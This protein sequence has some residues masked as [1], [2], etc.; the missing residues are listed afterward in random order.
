MFCPKCGN[1]V[2]DNSSFCTGCGFKLDSN[3]NPQP[4]PQPKPQPTH[5]SEPTPVR[6][7]ASEPI[8]PQNNSYDYY[9]KPPKKSGGIGV[10][11][12]I[13]LIVA[14]LVFSVLSYLLL[15]GINGKW[16]YDE[17]LLDDKSVE[18]TLK[19]LTGPYGDLSEEEIDEKVK[20]IN[21]E[22]KDSRMEFIFGKVTLKLG[23]SQV[24]GSYE[25]KDGE[26]YIN[27][28]YAG[29][30]EYSFSTLKFSV[31]STASNNM[32]PEVDK[33]TVI[34][35]KSWTQLLIY[36]GIFLAL[37]AALIVNIITS[38]SLQKSMKKN[39]G[40][41]YD[42]SVDPLAS[43]PYTPAPT[44]ESDDISEP[45]ITDK[46]TPESYDNPQPEAKETQADGNTQ[47]PDNTP[48][49][50]EEKPLFG[51]VDMYSTKLSKPSSE[52]AEDI[53][54]LYE[55]SSDLK[56][57]Y[58]SKPEPTPKKVEII[59]TP[60]KSIPTVSYED[61]LAAPGT[62][63]QYSTPETTTT[64]E[65]TVVPETPAVSEI[66]AVS[67]T[68]I[69]SEVPVD[70]VTPVVTETSTDIKNPEAKNPFFKSPGD[71]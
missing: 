51:S 41:S 3:Q 43:E 45:Y 13:V 58:V 68:P 24:A 27:D 36:A 71:L 56:T 32:P 48:T 63:K 28:N 10:I 37:V 59:F 67:E 31:K 5:Y 30:V 2:K 25:I 60:E 11:L 66:P 20:T 70:S 49:Y 39:T 54:P 55:G 19:N 57:K 34:L 18:E 47:I 35:H 9:S 52:P 22:Y 69:A 38:R 17:Y 26:L 6:R 64:P 44:A 62:V 12:S 65:A 8:K 50:N 61:Y 23:Q 29:D 1:N 46:K 21:N 42:L 16:V 4:A 33:C 7:S 53:A 40:A 14:I 15:N